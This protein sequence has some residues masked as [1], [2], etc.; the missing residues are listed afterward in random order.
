MENLPAGD[1]FHPQK[2]P[3]PGD[4]GGESANMRSKWY[5]IELG[6]SDEAP[7]RQRKGP[8]PGL[9]VK[10]NLRRAAGGRGS[11]TGPLRVGE[12]RDSRI[13]ERNQFWSTEN[14]SRIFDYG[15]PPGGFLSQQRMIQVIAGP[16]PSGQGPGPGDP[17]RGER[18]INGV[19]FLGGRTRFSSMPIVLGAGG[20]PDGRST[21]ALGFHADRLNG[22]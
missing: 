17:S 14:L 20:G 8:L 7:R 9:I 4:L 19:P 12:T 18:S 5:G 21:K 2:C 3:F 22:R 1:V 15:G 11:Q 6:I 13:A 16:R 10:C